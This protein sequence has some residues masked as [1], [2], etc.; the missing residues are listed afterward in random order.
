MQSHKDVADVAA[1]ATNIT[2]AKYATKYG[3]SMFLN[4]G[5]CPFL[6]LSLFV[7]FPLLPFSPSHVLSCTFVTSQ[8]LL[9]SFFFPSV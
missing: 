3:I 8:L 6:R 9:R 2:S 1:I 7:P 4:L 5:V